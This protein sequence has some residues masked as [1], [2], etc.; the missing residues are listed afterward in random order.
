MLRT[1]C[2]HVPVADGA[3][4]GAVVRR[5]ASE[6]GAA[7]RRR[8]HR[9]EEPVGAERAVEV[10]EDQAGLD[11]CHPPRTSTSTM[12]RR[13]LLQSRTTAS[14]TSVRTATSRRR[15]EGRGCRP[16]DRARAPPG[17]R[18]HR[19][20]HHARE[21]T[22]GRWRRRSRRGLARVGSEADL[23]RTSRRRRRSS[24]LPASGDGPITPD[25]VGRGRPH[26]A[27]DLLLRQLLVRPHEEA[28][29]AADGEDAHRPP[30]R[31]VPVAGPVDDIAEVIGDTMAASAEPVFISPL[32]V[33]ENFGAMSIG[34]AHIGPI[35][36]SRRRTPGAGSTVTGQVAQVQHRHQ[37]RD[38]R[39]VP[40]RRTTLRRAKMH[41]PVRG[42]ADR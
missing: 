36:N 14:P 5:H 13:C 28:G 8:I 16:R 30:E 39:Q 3:R 12:R 32:A 40:E 17:R 7:R 42:D 20:N 25:S 27:R 35:A 38:R 23:A 21:G 22:P 37:A 4:A 29:H 11:P 6:G 10:V 26:R 34:M 31:Q 15:G 24:A 18:S 9:E 19:G 41:R 1:L 2:D 33:P